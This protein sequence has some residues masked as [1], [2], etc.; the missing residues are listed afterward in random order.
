MHK[1]IKLP[2]MT[3]CLLLLSPIIASA[4]VKIIDITRQYGVTID[5]DVHS[6]QKTGLR[7]R[8][9]CSVFVDG[10]LVQGDQIYSMG[11]FNCVSIMENSKTK[12]KDIKAKCE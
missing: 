4:E 12:G 1:M 11:M 2:I 6:P 9:T 5:I 3:F 7:D 8:I 10:K